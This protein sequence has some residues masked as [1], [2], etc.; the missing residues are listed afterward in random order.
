MKVGV[1]YDIAVRHE[2]LNGQAYGGKRDWR[3]VS[4][5]RVPTDAG[6]LESEIHAKLARH[7]IG[8]PYMRV[9]GIVTTRETFVPNVD[10]ALVVVVA[11]PDASASGPDKSP[12][13]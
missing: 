12:D 8:L 1:T 4:Q 11:T 2:S 7:A 13:A 9:E 5:R 3:I 10:E 6:R